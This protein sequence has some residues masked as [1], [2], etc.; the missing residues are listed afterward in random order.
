[1]APAPVLQACHEG[2]VR[3]GCVDS[4]TKI[5]GR[6]VQSAT[7]R[8]TAVEFVGVALLREIPGS[9]GGVE[10]TEKTPVS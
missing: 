2:S 9:A 4:L 1:M 10:S 7:V 5:K 6:S 3:S 8:V